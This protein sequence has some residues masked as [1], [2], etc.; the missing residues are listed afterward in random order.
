MK[1]RS[2]L[3]TQHSALLLIQELVAGLAHADL[4]PILHGAGT[5][6]RAFIAPL[7]HDHEIGYVD[8]CF[9]R[10]DP[11]L[12]VPLRICPGMLLNEVQALDHRP[13]LLAEDPEHLPRLSLFLA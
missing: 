4:A 9:L 10:Q 5:H 13:T 11:A 6:A 12:D 2:S 8:R 1:L 3:M 7:A